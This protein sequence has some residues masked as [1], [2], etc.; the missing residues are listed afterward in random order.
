MENRL[1]LAVGLSL[2]VLFLLMQ[3]SP[4]ADDAGAKAGDA[5]SQASPLEDQAEL[6]GTVE[7]GASGMDALVDSSGLPVQDIRPNN[8]SSPWASLPSIREASP[9]TV[10]VT[11]QLYEVS[12]STHGGLPTH[13]HLK[14]AAGNGNYHE[15]FQ[16]PRFLAMRAEQ[17]LPLDPWDMRGWILPLRKPTS[18]RSSFRDYKSFHDLI[19]D[20][21]AYRE[22]L[23]YES[24]ERGDVNIR[25]GLTDAPLSLVDSDLTWPF[26][27]LAGEWGIRETRTARRDESILYTASEIS[28]DVRDRPLSLVFS[29]AGEG[30]RIEKEFIFSPGVYSVSGAI[31]IFNEGDREIEWRG[32]N[33]YRLVW[34]GG[35]GRPSTAYDLLNSVQIGWAD[36][37]VEFMNPGAYQSIEDGLVERGL[38]LPSMVNVDL[39]EDLFAVSRQYDDPGF[40]D[41]H[42]VAVDNKYFTAAIIPRAPGDM[43]TLG[44][45]YVMGRDASTY[46]IRPEAGIVMPAIAA[47]PPGA[48][49]E[50]PFMLYVGPKDEERLEN[51][52]ATGSLVAIKQVTFASIVRPITR[53]MMWFLKFLHGIVPNYGVCILLLTLV[54]KALMFPLYHKQ[55]LSMKRMQAL[56]PQINALKEQYKNDPQRLQRETMEFYKRNK[57]NPAAGCLPML[58]MMP[59]F[60]A[61]WV[62]FNNSLEL[63]GEPFIWWIDDLSK[64]D[65]AFFLPVLGWIIPIN[66]LPLAYALAM[67]WSQSRQQ[68]PDNPNANVMRFIPF[69]FIFFFWN[70]ASGV[71]LYFVAGILI[72]TVQRLIMDAFGIG[73]RRRT[74]RGARGRRNRSTAAKRGTAP[75]P[76]SI[77]A[78][79]DMKAARLLVPHGCRQEE[80][81]EE[82]VI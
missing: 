79:D 35:L 58:P 40:K 60:I 51:L 81:E 69:I 54:V 41:I 33:R 64:P 11:T 17:P 10:I 39:G 48:V 15:I 36:D 1:F 19:T 70:F 82:K 72:D 67:F 50:D 71:I 32:E 76:G 4:P 66:V 59:I 44:L 7:S 46:L 6:G 29:A 47:L 18:R 43:V 34:R 38:E 53:V 65:N 56:Q 12:F 31:R 22:Y 8:G 62:T 74:G 27:G 68:M 13:W 49:R 20:H 28:L 42:W 61:L 78:A 75:G 9:E 45:D 5:V 16:D 30:L 24:G 57:I 14:G 80:A 63:R 25:G 3:G 21:L 77:R 23:A 2:V 37:D 73:K 52:D 26:T 55:Q